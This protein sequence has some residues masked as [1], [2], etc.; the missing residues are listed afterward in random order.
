MDFVAS[1]PLPVLPVGPTH[2][3][4]A[5]YGPDWSGL[6]H[7]RYVTG[8]EGGVIWTVGAE[9]S[10]PDETDDDPTAG[11]F[12]MPHDH[13]APKD[14]KRRPMGTRGGRCLGIGRLRGVG[15]SRWS[16]ARWVAGGF[17]VASVTPDALA[18][19][20]AYVKEA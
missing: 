7:V 20:T 1:E 12:I 16:I 14:G 3:L 2:H 19:V 15:A 17:D 4:L 5:F 10:G 11:V 18:V 13:W 8:L 9:G 6:S